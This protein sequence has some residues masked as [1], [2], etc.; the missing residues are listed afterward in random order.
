MLDKNFDEIF[1]EKLGESHSFQTANEDW[2]N[3]LPR[4]EGDKVRLIPYKVYLVA[5]TVAMLLLANGYT[6]YRLNSSEG[7]LQD[8][9]ASLNEQ[10]EQIAAV[11]AQNPVIA[12]AVKAEPTTRTST[13]AIIS[14]VAFVKKRPELA[15]ASRVTD[16]PKAVQVASAQRTKR[17]LV[18]SEQSSLAL[19]PVW[20][21]KRFNAPRVNASPGQVNGARLQL[22]V[23]GNY[24]NYNKKN[25][26]VKSASQF[27]PSQ[28]ALLNRVLDVNEMAQ[29][30]KEQ[31]KALEGESSRV[32]SLTE[33]AEALSKEKHMISD[34]SDQKKKNTWYNTF[35]LAGVNVGA[36]VGAGMLGDKFMKVDANEV[37]E[38]SVN[39]GIRLEFD[40][41][42]DLRLFSD[43][44]YLNINRWTNDFTNTAVPDIES[45]GPEYNLDAVVLN[46]TFYQYTLGMKYFIGDSKSWQPFLGSGFT[47]QLAANQKYKYNYINTLTDEAAQTDLETQDRSFIYN[48]VNI[49]AGMEY[50]LSK[51]FML[52]LEGYYN[53]NIK[54]E[55][56]SIPNLYGLKATVLCNI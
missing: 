4:L 45:P 3:L 32:I 43:V 12:E 13:N 53:T 33:S 9:R 36:I 47:S 15:I 11:Q 16:T 21:G 42:G 50:N 27:N 6:L 23:S 28:K 37:L 38:G 29:A 34:Q 52:Q 22:G 35:S 51:N 24:S 49:N 7:Q 5:A 8:I 14:S 56:T 31:A 41:A 17:P 44:E 40:F 20:T 30:K 2:E 10:S 25:T 26:A 1:G 54:K 48:T 18:F 39:A 55:S 19:M 46:Q